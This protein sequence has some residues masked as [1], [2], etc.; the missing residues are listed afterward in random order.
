MACSQAV[1]KREKR[2]NLLV[3]N[4]ACNSR[5][6]PEEQ[7]RGLAISLHVATGG[8]AEE[9]GGQRNGTGGLWAELHLSL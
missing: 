6:D 8:A 3:V 4:S 7:R 2:A 5:S 1:C 9:M